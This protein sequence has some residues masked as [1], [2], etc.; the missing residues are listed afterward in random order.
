[1]HIYFNGT[2][3]GTVYRNDPKHSIE[4]E[5]L[6]VGGTL[7]LL[8]ENLGRVGFG[9]DVLLGDRKGILEYICV[10]GRA[11]QF[12]C[13]WEVYTLPMTNKL[14]ALSYLPNPRKGLPTFYRGTFKAEKGKDCFIHPDGFTKGFIVVNG[15]NLGRYW[16]IGPQYSVY[17]PWPILKEENEIIVFDEEPTEHP[18]V[19]ILDH[20]VLDLIKADD[21]PITIV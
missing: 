19:N 1:M 18:Y 20:H 12:L 11:R 14:G 15:F 10:Q 9:P 7:D 5:W 21:T 13:N 8:I 16:K 2:Y 6:E 17:L 3:K 4:A